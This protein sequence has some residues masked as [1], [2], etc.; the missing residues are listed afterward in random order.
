MFVYTCILL[1]VWLLRIAST[2]VQTERT[3]PAST[4]Y[5]C[6]LAPKW[7]SNPFIFTVQ[8]PYLQTKK[9]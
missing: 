3:D 5:V 2:L 9:E 6:D 7:Q 1:A 4:L 8:R